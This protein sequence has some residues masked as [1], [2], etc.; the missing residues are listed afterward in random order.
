M[1]RMESVFCVCEFKILCIA[2][3]CSGALAL[4]AI[5]LLR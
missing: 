3:A 1:E 2:T 5:L 4:G